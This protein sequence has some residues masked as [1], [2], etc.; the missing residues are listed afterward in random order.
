MATIDVGIEIDNVV[1]EYDGETPDIDILRDIKHRV[2]RIVRHHF[3]SIEE[4]RLQEITVTPVH[5]GFQLMLPEELQGP[6]EK[7]KEEMGR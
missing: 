6:M 3:P 2:I 5:D 4:S 1:A 7:F